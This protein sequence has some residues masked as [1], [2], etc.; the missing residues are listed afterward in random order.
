[1]VVIFSLVWE[2]QWLEA[3][4]MSK[5]SHAV[6]LHPYFEIR[7]GNLDAFLALMPKF[8]EATSNEAACV[9]YDFS[10]NG[11]TAFCREAYVGA[12]GILAHLENVGE[13]LG[14]FLELA[15]L[16]RLEVHGPAEEIEK[17]RGP[18]AEL[19]PAF[20]IRETGLE[21]N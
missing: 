8:V 4:G 1:M 9:Y 3:I 10:R 5:L 11:N 21:S 19:K 17:L 12:E 2:E 20:F 15:D 7:E 16:I 13:L 6:S 14:K 18:L